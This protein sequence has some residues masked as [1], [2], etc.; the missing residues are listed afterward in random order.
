[1]FSS[2]ERES[3]GTSAITTQKQML[4]IGLLFPLVSARRSL[5]EIL[6]LGRACF[7][8]GRKSCPTN[9]E[10]SLD[11]LVLRQVLLHVYPSHLTPLR[12]A[13]ANQRVQ[14]KHGST[15]GCQR[16]RRWSQLGSP[17]A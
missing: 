9:K 16:S 3:F 11:C 7:N 5:K 4:K 12:S 6:R 1:M 10:L 8:S 17:L 2:Q 14:T 15:D 13:S